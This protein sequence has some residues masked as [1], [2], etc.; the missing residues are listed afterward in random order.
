MTY[1][2]Y[3]QCSLYYICYSGHH[4]DTFEHTEA[5]FDVEVFVSG[6]SSRV[7]GPG[8]GTRAGKTFLRLA[9][10]YAALPKLM[11]MNG[12]V[13][14][15]NSAVVDSRSNS[16]QQEEDLLDLSSLPPRP[17]EITEESELKELER[18]LQE[19]DTDTSS[20]YS[21]G[22]SVSSMSSNSSAQP[23]GGFSD[24]LQRFHANL[25][26]RLHPFWSSALGNRTVRLSV[27]SCNPDLHEA[28]KSPPLGAIAD[29]EDAPQRQPIAT[30]EVQTAADGSFQMKFK[31]RWEDMCVHPGAVHIAF[32]DPRLEHEL[33]VQAQLLPPPS[34]PPTPS[35][36]SAYNNPNASSSQF[37]TRPSADVI[38]TVVTCI[39][40]PLTHTT[41]RLISDIDDTVKMSGVLQG[42][43]ALF[44][45]VFV[46]DLADGVIPGMGDW[47][48]SMWRRGVRFHYVS[49]GPFELLP[50][51]NE[52]IQLS[53]L[54]PGSIKLKSYAGRSLF[55]GLLSAPAERKRIGIVDVLDS[56]PDARF[57]LVGDSGEQDLEL[58]ASLA[59]ERPHQILAIF[60]R[61]AG[62]DR[63][64][65]LEDPTGEKGMFGWGWG[66]SNGQVSAASSPTKMSF[67]EKDRAGSSS[68]SESPR[69][70]PT[71]SFSDIQTPRPRT[72][73]RHTGRSSTRT[74]SYADTPGP[75]AYPYFAPSSSQTYGSPLDV[76]PGVMD[77]SIP[78][79]EEPSEM[80]TP[81]IPL[82]PAKVPLMATY[83][84]S[85]SPP[86]YGTHP[87]PSP[88]AIPP[89]PGAYDSRISSR[90][91]NM[92][93]RMNSIGTLGSGPQG[94]VLSE[95]EKRQNELQTR[96]YRARMEV[97]RHIPLRVFR[98]PEECFEDAG[99]ILDGL[100][101]GVA[102]S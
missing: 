66:S 24:N 71:R 30:R 44:Q 39:S 101:L 9:K 55:N 64:L 81:T 75:S 58:Y 54:P 61:D 52:F 73:P 33:Y 84:P 10:R 79:T 102:G 17:D 89:R 57:F 16:L 7:S 5:P 95:P 13:G 49:N 14:T 78:I 83:P 93:S 69:V 28:Y 63:S 94:Q 85:P 68:G 8:F 37:F 26:A 51:V 2:F 87:T 6:F 88:L 43:R 70:S 92:S 82:P 22:S 38:P 15:M 21:S 4:T 67:S 23:Q 50:V 18:Q 46:K 77:S 25:E 62:G 41:I 100:H 97:P 98:S 86:P 12:T 76:Y 34:R 11:A 36:Y 1:L 53:H 20:L 80:P 90:S 59:K 40:V 29:D 56:F 72:A 3:R 27:F 45:N 42:A 91:S 48:T 19:L 60:I 65:P 99:V 74:A 96:V 47:Y 32:G 35:S 31:L